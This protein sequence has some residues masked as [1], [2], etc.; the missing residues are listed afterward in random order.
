MPESKRASRNVSY[1]EAVP[2]MTTATD[3]REVLEVTIELVDVGT[4]KSKPKERLGMQPANEA[5]LVGVARS[6]RGSNMANRG[7]R[8]ICFYFGLWAVGCQWRAEWRA[9]ESF[10]GVWRSYQH[11]RATNFVL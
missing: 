11:T 6:Y 4:C 2:R 3:G 8:M 10:G 1:L 9:V 7:S 5:L